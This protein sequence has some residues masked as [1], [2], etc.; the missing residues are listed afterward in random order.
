MGPNSVPFL[1]AKQRLNFVANFFAHLDQ[2]WPF[3]LE[4]FARHFLRR[5]DAEFAA[6]GDFARRVVEHVGRAF[7][8]E[9]SRLRQA[10]ARQARCGLAAPC[11]RRGGSGRRRPVLALSRFDKSGTLLY[12]GVLRFYSDIRS[13]AKTTPNLHRRATDV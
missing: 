6:A 10:S 5:I 12:P 3:A 8:E 2:G 1:F 7:G 9:L 11:W 4:T 13:Q